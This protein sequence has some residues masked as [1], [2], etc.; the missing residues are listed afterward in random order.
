MKPSS[1][2]SDMQYGK[3]RVKRQIGFLPS[4]SG[5][6]VQGGTPESSA[7]EPARPITWSTV[8]VVEHATEK[9]PDLVDSPSHYARLSPQPVEVIAAWDLDFLLGSAVGYIAR[10]GFKDGSDRVTDLKKAASCIQRKI[11][12]LTGGKLVP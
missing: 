1:L 9:G 2:V 3:K 10:A 4:G 7:L 5:A 8:G 12:Q 6:L 11:A